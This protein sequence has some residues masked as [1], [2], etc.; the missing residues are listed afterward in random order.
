MSK[1]SDVW[2]PLSLT[3]TERSP[4]N[5]NY[6]YTLIARLRP[7]F[8]TDQAETAA[9]SA[10]DQ[11]LSQMPPGMDRQVENSSCRASS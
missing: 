11:I 3:P 9:H 5:T 4:Q 10:I 1:S 2:V 7:G 8:S 6:S